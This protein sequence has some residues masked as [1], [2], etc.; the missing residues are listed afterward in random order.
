MYDYFGKIKEFWK[1]TEVGNTAILKENIFNFYV[2][3]RMFMLK[4]WRHMLESVYADNKFHD[5]F[6]DFMDTSISQEEFQD[7]LILQFQQLVLEEI[8]EGFFG[9]FQLRDKW[10]CRNKREQIEV[11]SI[12][13]LTAQRTTITNKRVYTLFNIFIQ[14]NFGTQ[15]PLPDTAKY[16]SIQDQQALSYAHIVCFFVVWEKQWQKNDTSFWQSSDVS[17]LDRSIIH[18]SNQQNQCLF[19]TTWLGLK[20]KMWNNVKDGADLMKTFEKVP[21]ETL[22]RLLQHPMCQVN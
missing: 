8:P 17:L 11:L 19:A 5:Q 15:P 9:G 18:L 3:E 2:A 6:Q 14:N 7:N 1:V 20:F 16:I 21:F 22:E 10:F 12:L 4:V 13:A